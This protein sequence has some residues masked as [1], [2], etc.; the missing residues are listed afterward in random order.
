MKLE[1]LKLTNFRNYSKVSFQPSDKIN[2]LYGKN[3]SGKE[4]LLSEQ[5]KSKAVWY[6][7]DADTEPNRTNAAYGSDRY[8]PL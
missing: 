7:M 4:S 6:G 5:S 1:L 8:D 2:I 3:G